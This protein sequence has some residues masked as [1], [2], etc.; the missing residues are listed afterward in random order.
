MPKRA[1]QTA[2]HC[3]GGPNRNSPINAFRH[4]P[5]EAAALTP[6]FPPQPEQFRQRLSPPCRLSGPYFA[7]DKTSALS[8]GNLSPCESAESSFLSLP[9]AD[10]AHS[11]RI[12]FFRIS[13]HIDGFSHLCLRF[14]RSRRCAKPSPLMRVPPREDSVSPSSEPENPRFPIADFQDAQFAACPSIAPTEQS[15]DS[16][17]PFP[18]LLCARGRLTVSDDVYSVQRRNESGTGLRP[19]AA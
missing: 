13:L 9:E 8:K 3:I 7:S 11:V 10:E 1:Q 17:A 12:R 16:F 5:I 14:S 19:P 4:V 18:L 6:V 15:A 2:A